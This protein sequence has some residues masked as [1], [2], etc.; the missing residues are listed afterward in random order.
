MLIFVWRFLDSQDNQ[1]YFGDLQVLNED[2]YILTNIYYVRV[3]TPIQPEGIDQQAQPNI[4][5]AKLG[6]ELHGPLDVMY[7]RRDK[8][9]YW[10][11]LKDD[12]QV[13][14]AI[15][16]FEEDRDSGASTQTQQQTPTTTPA[17]STQP[18]GTPQQDD[19]TGTGTTPTP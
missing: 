11:N 12:G 8:V 15:T 17:G 13:A 10:E 14:T 2:M 4:S 7:I 5:L 6:N 9:L 1:V 19:T 18:A 3:E 16:R